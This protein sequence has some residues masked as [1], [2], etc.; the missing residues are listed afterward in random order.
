MTAALLKLL[1]KASYSNIIA[2]YATPVWAAC[3]T[4]ER[5]KETLIPLLGEYATLSWVHCIN[6]RFIFIHFIRNRN[7]IN[8]KSAVERQLGRRPP[9]ERMETLLLLRLRDSIQGNTNGNMD[10]DLACAKLLSAMYKYV[11]EHCTFYKPATG[12]VN[13]KRP[14]TVHTAHR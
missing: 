4:Q 9:G 8:A 7:Y 2:I 14:T 3:T 11:E 12:I 6:I 5:K 13:C 10:C 1:R